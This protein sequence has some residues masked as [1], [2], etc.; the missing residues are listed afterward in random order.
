MVQN[1]VRLLIGNRV[2]GKLS[3][4][5]GGRE[6]KL[7]GGRSCLAGGSFQEVFLRGGGYQTFD[8]I[9]SDTKGGMLISP[10]QDYREKQLE[11][12][13]SCLCK[14]ARVSVLP[15]VDPVHPMPMSLHNNT[16]FPRLPESTLQQVKNRPQK[17]YLRTD[18]NMGANAM[19]Q[20]LVD[21]R[22]QV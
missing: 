15:G 12:A 22:V 3:S 5:F 20:T 10:L 1:P 21:D 17:S 16:F 8:L 18:D 19:L 2:W 7:F 11:G 4:F 14:R 13:H 6:V 9:S